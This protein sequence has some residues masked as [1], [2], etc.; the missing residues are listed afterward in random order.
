MTKRQFKPCTRCGGWVYEDIFYGEG[1]KILLHICINCGSVQ[2]S[3]IIS[4]VKN[5][6]EVK[7]MRSKSGIQS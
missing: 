7:V 3:K 2:D 1:L 4:I 5:S 6:G